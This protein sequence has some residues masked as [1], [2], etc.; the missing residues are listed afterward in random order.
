[1]DVEST[2]RFRRAHPF[3][4]KRLPSLL[5]DPFFSS[6]QHRSGSNTRSFY[7]YRSVRIF[8]A[9]RVSWRALGRLSSRAC[10]SLP[11]PSPRPLDLSLSLRPRLLLTTD[12]NQ[13][14]LSPPLR[15]TV[16][17]PR[18]FLGSPLSQDDGTSFLFSFDLSPPPRPQ[19]RPSSTMGTYKNTRSSQTS[20]SG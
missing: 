3:E 5:R 15:H 17:Q 10:S 14:F 4:L 13:H 12:A 18:R 6:T 8:S 2:R 20:A 16:S 9:V 11:L 1:M 19:T 7:P